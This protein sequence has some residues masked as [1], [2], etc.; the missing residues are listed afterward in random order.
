VC[1]DT[2]ENP[3][4]ILRDLPFSFLICREHFLKDLCKILGNIG[5]NL[6]RKRKNQPPPPPPPITPTPP[7]TGRPSRSHLEAK[8]LQ[9]ASALT[10]VG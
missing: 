6:F 8:C 5:R 4:I 10:A 9:S 2:Y 3:E 7:K 1:L